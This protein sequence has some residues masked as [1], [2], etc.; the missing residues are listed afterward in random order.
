[1]VAALATMA[2]GDVTQR[3]ARP[4]R[5][6]RYGDLLATGYLGP[7]SHPRTNALRI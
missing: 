7:G 2:L 1:M 6:S 5:P 3:R 4:G